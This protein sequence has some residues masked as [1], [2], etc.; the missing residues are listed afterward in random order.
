MGFMI[1]RKQPTSRAVQEFL[2]RTI[3]KNG[4]KPKYIVTDKGGQFWRDGS[5]GWCKAKKI[6]PRFGAIGKL[7]SAA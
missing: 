6:K 3:W 1:F 2:D 7:R 4:P 5:K